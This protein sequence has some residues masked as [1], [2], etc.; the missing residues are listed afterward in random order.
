MITIEQ[1][2]NKLPYTKAEYFKWKFGI[3]FVDRG[4]VTEEQ[5]LKR[6]RRSNIKV[7]ER[8]ER[9]EE[10]KNLVAIYL[11]SKTANDLL[12]VYDVVSKKAKKGDSRCIEQLL[13]LQ[14]EIRETAKLADM[15]FNNSSKK[16]KKEDDGDNLII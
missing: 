14:K 11:N 1:A 8:W 3:G 9:T 15:S 10:Y 7:F 2:L 13:K 6:V 4:D 5:F 12:E 16:S